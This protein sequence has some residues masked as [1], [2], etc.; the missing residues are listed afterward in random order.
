MD[1]IK[2]FPVEIH[3]VHLWTFVYNRL[4]GQQTADQ[5]MYNGSLRALSPPTRPL[6]VHVGQAAGQRP[7]EERVRFTAVRV[8]GLQQVRLQRDQQRRHWV[9]TERVLQAQ[10][11]SSVRR[12]LLRFTSSHLIQQSE[13][14]EPPAPPGD[15]GH[16]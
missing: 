16:F 9:G 11:E 4:A 14:Y 2:R 7:G 10:E 1:D 5:R 3:F 15:I 8:C 6:L 12:R 13:S